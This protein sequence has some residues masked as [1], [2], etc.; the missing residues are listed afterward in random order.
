MNVDNSFGN[1]TFSEARITVAGVTY[2][3][4]EDLIRRFDETK[5][6][7]HYEIV[8]KETGK[9]VNPKEFLWSWIQKELQKEWEEDL[10]HFDLTNEEMIEIVKKY[11]EE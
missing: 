1:Q 9:K 6:N 2:Y 5:F 7:T 4:L 10:E 11:H 3:G 8:N